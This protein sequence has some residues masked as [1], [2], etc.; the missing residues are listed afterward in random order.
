MAEVISEFRTYIGISDSTIVD[1]GISR[2]EGKLHGDAIKDLP[3]KFQT[4]VPGGVG[5][6]TRLTLLTNLMEAY[7]KLTK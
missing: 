2:I 3:V 6:L 4:P 1:V 5:L 7:Y